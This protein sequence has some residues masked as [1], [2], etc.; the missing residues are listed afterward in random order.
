MNRRVFIGG[1]ACVALPPTLRVSAEERAKVWRIGFLREGI[2]PIPP[3]L[4]EALRGFGWVAGR[5][6]TFEQRFADHADQLPGLASDLVRR[7]SDLIVTSGTQSTRAAKEA[8]ADIP[9][10]FSVAGDPAERGLVGS[11]SRPGGNLTGVAQGIYDEKQLQILTAALPWIT[12]V[13]YPVFPGANPSTLISRDAAQ[14]IGVQIQH[15]AVQVADDFEPFFSAARNAAADAALIPDV[16]RLPPTS[17]ASGSRPRGT[18]CRRWAFGGCLR[19]RE[20]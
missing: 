12:R 9:I 2:E 16:G 19:R 18:A 17:S 1:M 14:A 7:Q 3:A 5:N 4:V 8:T 6:T 10:V 15:C 11:M 13:A 20:A